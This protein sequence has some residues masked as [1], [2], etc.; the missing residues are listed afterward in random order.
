MEFIYNNHL[1]ND[2]AIIIVIFHTSI[3]SYHIKNFKL[4]KTILENAS[5]PFFI[6]EMSIRNTPFIFKNSENIFHYHSDDFIFY[7]ENLINLVEKKIGPTFTKLCIIDSDIIFKDPD[8]YDKLSI[9]LDHCDVCQP[10]E[11][12]SLLNDDLTIHSKNKS[13]CSNHTKNGHTGYS[14]AFKR[15]IFH[16][17]KL[18]DF[19]I[20][21]NGN[22]LFSK[23][24][25]LLI[26]KVNYNTF[27]F[28][29]KFRYLNKEFRN[30]MRNINLSELNISFLKID[31]VHLYH[32]NY[33]NRLSHE[34]HDALNN[35]LNNNNISLTDVICYNSEGI[36]CFNEKN[37]NLLNSLLISYFT[38]RNK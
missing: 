9:L 31:I 16:Q 13:F 36:I 21:G 14:W 29:G 33:N 7:K 5:I 2:L 35:L 30:Y 15:Y 6:G 26:N 11:Y 34:R 1:R 3:N 19:C 28:C 25:H 4:I 23:M 22:M 20:I 17:V 27:V 32:G 10:F 8:W 38:Y 18:P 37:K 24:I 12:V